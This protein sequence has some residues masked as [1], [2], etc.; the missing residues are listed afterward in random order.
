MTEQCNEIATAWL[1]EPNNGP[2]TLITYLNYKNGEHLSTKILECPACGLTWTDDTLSYYE[3]IGTLTPMIAT[4]ET[5][6]IKSIK[7][8]ILNL[9][10]DMLNNSDN[11]LNR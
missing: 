3:E 4:I 9:V 8:Q 11:N 1:G 7:T 10:A 2:S 5:K 6:N